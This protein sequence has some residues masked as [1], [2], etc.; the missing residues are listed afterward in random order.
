MRQVIIEWLTRGA[1]FE[2]GRGYPRSPGQQDVVNS[3]RATALAA[4][5][6]V[7]VIGSVNA[8]NVVGAVING[9][10]DAYK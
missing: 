6:M 10:S 7:K 3:G 9:D 2:A 5:G 4:T 8:V 1:I